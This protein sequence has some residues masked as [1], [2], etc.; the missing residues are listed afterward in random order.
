MND[1]IFTDT[2]V[3]RQALAVYGFN[4]RIKV[5][6]AESIHPGIAAKMM[7][8][9]TGLESEIPLDVKIIESPSEKELRSTRKL[10]TDNTRYTEFR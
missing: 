10:D 5:R 6:K 3:V 4:E 1:N 8:E 2:Y 7:P 9:N